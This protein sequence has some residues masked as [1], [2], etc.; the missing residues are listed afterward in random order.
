MDYLK[1]LEED[2]GKFDIYYTKD[3][4]GNYT[5]PRACIRYSEGVVQEIRGVSNNQNLEDEIIIIKVKRKKKK[6]K[7]KCLEQINEIKLI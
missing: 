1:Y 6:E 2:N 4:D 5:I 7:K 3:V